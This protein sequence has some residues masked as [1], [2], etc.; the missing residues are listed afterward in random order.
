MPEVK[1]ILS[2]SMKEDGG[3][4]K[5]GKSGYCPVCGS[6]L[7]KMIDPNDSQKRIMVCPLDPT[8]QAPIPVE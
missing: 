2:K 6:R 7:R 3:D 1:T 5:K 8:H 4:E